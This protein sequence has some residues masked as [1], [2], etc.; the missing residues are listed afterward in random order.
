[1]LIDGGIT[2]AMAPEDASSPVENFS[3]YPELRSDGYIRRPTAA[4]VAGLDPEMAPKI[5]QVPTV[6]RARL[7]RTP[8][9]IDSTQSIIRFEIPP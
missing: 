4:T 8:P 7:P 3:S 1:M 9:M 2:I 5:V 6:V